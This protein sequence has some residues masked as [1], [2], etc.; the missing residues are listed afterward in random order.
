MG[1]EAAAKPCKLPGS[2]TNHMHIQKKLQYR[3]SSSH[4]ACR[5]PMLLV[6]ALVCTAAV[7]AAAGCRAAEV[8]SLVS[9]C[10]K[11][12]CMLFVD[13]LLAC[14]LNLLACHAGAAVWQYQDFLVPCQAPG[15]AACS[16]R[17]AQQACSR[18]RQIRHTENAHVSKWLLGTRQQTQHRGSQQH[19][20]AQH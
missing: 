5:H 9:S 3:R 7:Q 2:M 11:L 17:T 1:C 19:Q 16:N 20:P 15:T 13:I 8:S 4:S 18:S 12:C 6:L 14:K 10:C